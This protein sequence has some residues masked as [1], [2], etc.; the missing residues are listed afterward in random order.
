MGQNE[1]EWDGIEW[2]RKG[3][4]DIEK[5]ALNEKFDEKKQLAFLKKITFMEKY[6]KLLREH[7]IEFEDRYLL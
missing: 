1:T 6:I 2:H 4:E 3:Q 7:N 5:I